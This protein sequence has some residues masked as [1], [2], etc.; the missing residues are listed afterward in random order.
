MTENNQYKLNL[1]NLLYQYPPCDYKV[2]G[3][4]VDEIR[5][6]FIGNREKAIET[7]RV[8]FWASQYPGC[9]LNMTYAG[10][11]DDLIYVGNHF[12]DQ[13]AYPALTEYIQKGYADEIGLKELTFPESTSQERKKR[14][15][16][17]VAGLHIE[18]NL[19]KYIIVATG[20]AYKD[21]EC[22]EKIE[23]VCETYQEKLGRVFIGVYND[24]MNETFSSINWSKISKNVSIHQFELSEEECEKS[25]LRRMAAN[26]N[27]AYS[28]KVDQRLNVE[29]NIKEFE[30]TCKNEFHF[31]QSKSYNADASY[32]SA[33]HIFSKLA[34]C[35]AY[36]HVE[37]T[38]AE[39]REE[40][41]LELLAQA[42]EKQSELFDQ[43]TVLEHKRWNA[44]MVM[45]GYRYPHENEWGFVYNGTYKNVDKDRKL[46]V[47]LCEC[48]EK[49]NPDMEKPGFW[50]VMRPN[51]SPLDQASYRCN[52]IAG[53][54][55][56]E[57]HKNIYNNN[58]F[59]NSI[60]FKNLR[61]A[62]EAMFNEETQSITNYKRIYKKTLEKPE[63]KCNRE[64]REQLVAL[65]KMLEIVIIYNQRINFFEYD[66]QLVRMLPF[67]IWFGKKYQKVIV[68][69]KGIST[70]DVVVPTL[71][72]AK[73]AI[74]VAKESKDSKDSF[75][76]SYQYAVERYFLERGANTSAKFIVYDQNG[77]EEL[78]KEVGDKQEIVAGE[79][80][81]KEQFLREHSNAINLRYDA[82]SQVI[83]GDS[84][85]FIGL[86]KQSFSVDEFIRLLG[87]DVNSS[88]H[89]VLDEETFSCLEQ[90]FWNEYSILKEKGIGTDK[91]TWIPWNECA[92]AFQQNRV[93]DEDEN[94][95]I[96]PAK[97]DKIYIF[98]NRIE[99]KIY[100]E[101][102]FET[103]LA[104]LYDYHVIDQLHCSIKKNQVSICFIT[105]H[106]EICKIFQ[107]FCADDKRKNTHK[108]SLG[109]VIKN[110]GKKDEFLK[111]ESKKYKINPNNPNNSYVEAGFFMDLQD[112]GYCKNVNVSK[113]K[114]CSFTVQDDNVRKFIEFAG[115]VLE[116]SVYHKMRKS[117]VFD[118]VST[119][120]KFVWNAECKES[121]LGNKVLKEK[122]DKLAE[123]NPVGLKLITIQ[124]LINEEEKIASKKAD[125]PAN[126][127]GV[128]QEI[129]VIAIKGMQAYFVSC[130]NR[131]NIETGHLMEIGNESKK[132]N[133]VAIIATCLPANEALNETMMNRA[134]DDHI[135]VLSRE[136]LTDDEKFKVFL[137]T[138]MS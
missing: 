127:P 1:Y 20:D 38:D 42:I 102:N 29:N 62:I 91:K 55:V 23:A 137:S 2:P 94:I 43:L 10:S 106:N 32:A 118:D 109:N 98:N 130:K 86:E 14:V 60:I 93:S 111:L 37:C 19:Y 63:V 11:K 7:Y 72:Y 75:E 35:L 44:Y 97:K 36:H 119:G 73:E 112:K 129:D 135:A 18:E 95:A 107:L 136:E 15:F 51:L 100:K 61:E 30:E 133:A 81:D 59:L 3:E 12:R 65:D 132:A 27:L 88:E 57:L 77:K 121:N 69:S 45:R 78:E 138:I 76:P 41:G 128:T 122:A 33:V 74:F 131:I 123:T 66:A 101:N 83:K 48:G 84:N 21:W 4:E 16:E 53:E 64:L 31:P 82:D 6:L 54:K 9:K 96:S 40:K 39:E 22:L 49:Q 124:E 89:D 120:V 71:L 90:M 104:Q 114:L 80:Y 56:K 24:G 126:N 110:K 34:Y 25:E 67:C 70:Q 13:E 113:N 68:F 5:V 92:K 46:H 28:I 125:K 52:A 58:L 79:G 17:E 105:Y 47:C 50:K 134:K 115:G 103:I 26:I 8:L 117:G 108:I 87:G 116:K 85:L 99:E